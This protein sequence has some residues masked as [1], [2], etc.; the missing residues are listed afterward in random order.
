[1]DF[2]ILDNLAFYLRWGSGI[3]F[4]VGAIWTVIPLYH[5]NFAELRTRLS[6]WIPALAITVV[7]HSQK[8]A[9][10][11]LERLF[12]ESLEFSAVQWI[13]EAS[14]IPQEYYERVLP[15]C[16]VLVVTLYLSVRY[17]LWCRRLGAQKSDQ[18]EAQHQGRTGPIKDGQPLSF[19]A[20]SQEK[21]LDPGLVQH[22]QNTPSNPN[23][24]TAPLF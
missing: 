10:R 18:V 24:S 16:I 7:G 2:E 14:G 8:M 4:F 13:V 5:R 20:T 1:M 19:D 22:V 21:E 12:K 3:L 15:N 23:P 17:V 6:A 11:G 9:W